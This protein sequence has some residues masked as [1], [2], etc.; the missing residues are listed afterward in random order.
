MVF[1]FV[2]PW[3]LQIADGR[4][5]VF[6]GLKKVGANEHHVDK[7]EDRSLKVVGCGPMRRVVDNDDRENDGENVE[8]LEDERKRVAALFA[9]KRRKED[10][11]GHLNQRNLHRVRR[12]HL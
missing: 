10:Q 7:T 3:R 1:L 12:R 6:Q 8:R 4:I 2:C 9:P 11:R 5:D